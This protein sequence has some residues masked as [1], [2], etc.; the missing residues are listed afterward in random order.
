MLSIISYDIGSDRRRQ[1]ILT[2]LKDF[3][4]RWVQ[5]SV[6]ECDLDEATLRTLLERLR[7]L[8]QAEE[9]DSLRVYAVCGACRPSRSVIDRQAPSNLANVPP[10]HEPTR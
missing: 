9:G 8:V 4:G 1:K 6:F 10:C 2:A 3:G 5:Y 7:P